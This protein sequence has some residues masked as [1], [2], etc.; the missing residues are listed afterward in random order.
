MHAFW[1]ASDNISRQQ[2]VPFEDGGLHGLVC[3]QACYS[4]LSHRL[5]YLLK[6]RD[7]RPLAHIPG[8]AIF[9]KGNYGGILAYH[10][11]VAIPDYLSNCS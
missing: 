9:M 7:V 1:L 8:E 10:D 4:L 3:H 6:I 5:K 11:Q 2:F